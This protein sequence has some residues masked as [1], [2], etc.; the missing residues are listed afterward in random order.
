MASIKTQAPETATGEVADIYAQITNFFGGVPTPLRVLSAN[1]LWLRQ[2][3][4]AMGYYMSH[5]TLSFAT[6]A[7]L[8]MLVSMG[9]ECAY[10]IDR[11]AAFLIERAGW[12]ADQV[13]AAKTDLDKS[14]LSERERAM[15]K[16]AV[17]ASKAP[18]TVSEADIESLRALG[19][20]DADI[21]DGIQH[22][23]RMVAMDILIDAFKVER[24]F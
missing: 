8:R 1:P 19:W 14:P 7:T 20:S 18:R 22:A 16:V 13:A 11:N 12:T 24:D 15:V 5:P 9:T 21:L 10:C 4:E 17:K 3:V 6:L 2:Q 23:A